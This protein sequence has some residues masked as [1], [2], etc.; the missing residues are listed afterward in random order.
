MNCVQPIA[1]AFDGPMLQPKPDSIWVI[2]ASTCHLSPKA[3]AAADHVGFRTSALVHGF[4]ARTCEWTLG[5]WP[6]AFGTLAR[7]TSD[8]LPTLGVGV[9]LGA[10]LG[11]LLPLPPELWCPSQALS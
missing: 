7:R 11:A 6:R 1:P 2:A 10:L 8:P 3:R 4:T 5:W 9:L